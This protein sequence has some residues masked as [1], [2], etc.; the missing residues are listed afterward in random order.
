MATGKKE[1]T[2]D[3]IQ[4]H[5]MSGIG[6]MIP[7]IMGYTLV[8]GIGE[9]A[10]AFLG[11]SVSAEGALTDPNAIIAFLAWVE[12]VAAPA[13]QDLMYPVFAGYLAYSVGKRPALMPGFV[14]GAIAYA[15]GSGFIGALAIGFISGYLMKWVSANW[16]VS[17]AYSSIMNFTVYP[18]VGT[19]A[20]FVLMYFIVNPIGSAITNW[21]VS[22]IGGLGA[23][24]AIPFAIAI[25]SMMAFD[26]GGPVNKAAFTICV[27][28]MGT[29]AN[30]IPLLVGAECAPL[31]Q[32]AAWILNKTVFGGKALPEEVEEAGLPA[33]VMGALHVTEGALPALLFDPAGM[34]PINI[35][36]SAVAA[37]LAEVMGIHMDQFAAFGLL[38]GK[39]LQ[40]LVAMLAG[41]LVIGFLTCLR[42]KSVM[43]KRAAEESAAE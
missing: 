42:M 19:L 2:W 8:K 23:Y 40:Y 43:K 25:A 28:L 29:G 18:F 10:G 17:R 41:M 30:M 11:F 3:V 14:G 20:V 16:K 9:V 36:G 13:A 12:Q 6:Y 27:T 1:S 37:T 15:G 33:L 4:K 26:C 38:A 22:V 39:P 35:I 21:L 34:I 24:G 7:L 31:G 5:M 32:G